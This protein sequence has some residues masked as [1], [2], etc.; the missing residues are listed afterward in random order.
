MKK[1]FGLA[2]GLFIGFVMLATSASAKE[3]SLELSNSDVS[4]EG[5]SIWRDSSYRITGRCDGLVYPYETQ[6]DHY[7]LWARL[8]NG[9]VTR[10]DDIDRGYFEG[11]IFDAYTSLFI[12]AEMSSSPRRPSTKEI[13]S[14]SVTAFDF[15]KSTTTVQ[16]TPAPSVAP[17]TTTGGITVQN[18]TTATSSSTVGGVVGKILTSLLVIVAVIVVITIV[19]SLLFRRRGSVSA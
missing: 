7:V 11:S 15:D 12:T 3:G 1:I 8:A 9:N 16:P 13:V 17:K 10:I 19:A 5:I 4:C 14:G 18:P 2:T 6:Y